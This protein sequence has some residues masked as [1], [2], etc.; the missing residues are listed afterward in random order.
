M[1]A[2]GANALRPDPAALVAWGSNFAPY[3]LDGEPW[4]LLTGAFVHIGFPHLLSNMVVLLLLGRTTERLYGNLRFLALYLFAAVSGGIVSILM[5]PGVNSAGASGAIFGVAGALLA[6][7]LRYRKELPAELAARNRRAMLVFILYSLYR[8]LVQHGVDNAAHFGGL[9]GGVLI[10]A[11]LARPLT[12]EARERSSRPSA[13]AATTAAVLF[14]AALS[15]P[16][17]HLNP[18]RLQEASFDRL[19]IELQPAQKKT[20]ADVIAWSHSRIASQIERDAASNRII[21]QLL[22]EWDAMY[23]KV[24]SAPLPPGSRYVPLRATMLRYLDDNRR[25]YRLAAVLLAHPQELDAAA[26]APIRALAK[27]AHAQIDEIKRLAPQ[28]RG[29]PARR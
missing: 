28:L 2:T 16:L 21:T 14:L 5:H 8:G 9:V 12:E 7:V 22:P 29:N 18:D 10:G 11:L 13:I 23:A 24:E 26:F 15:W 27:D 25:M 6:F 20:L 1:C 3:T 4:R 19:L 17:T